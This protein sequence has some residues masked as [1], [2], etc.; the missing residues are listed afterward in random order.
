[1]I[2]SYLVIKTIKTTVMSIGI[3]GLIGVASAGV[4]V[5]LLVAPEK[6]KTLRKKIMNGSD[7]FSH[8]IKVQVERGKEKIDEIKSKGK[9]LLTATEMKIKKLKQSLA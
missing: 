1:M 2:G 4:L 5:G 6:G 8:M 7:E 3:K 9:E